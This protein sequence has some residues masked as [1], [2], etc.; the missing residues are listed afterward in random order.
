MTGAMQVVSDV[1][2]L[3]HMVGGLRLA[4]LGAT[5]DPRALWWTVLVTLVAAGLAVW[6]ARRRPA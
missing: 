5:D 3:S 2:P 6:R 1:V 4:W